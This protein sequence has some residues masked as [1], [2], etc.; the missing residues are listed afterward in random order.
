MSANAQSDLLNTYYQKWLVFQKG[1]QYL[2][3][4]YIYLNT[5]YIRKYKFSNADIEFGDVDPSEQLMEISELGAYLWKVNMIIPLQDQL[6]SYL[7]AA[8]N[9]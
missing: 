4:L 1:I 7:L 9:E 5:Q 8:I 2:S 3:T 6:V